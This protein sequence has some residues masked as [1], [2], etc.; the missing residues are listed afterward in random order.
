MDRYLMIKTRDE[1]LRIKIGQILYFEADRN[2]TKL[3]LS[4][5]IQFTFAINIG[6][7]EELLEKQVSGSNDMLV[8]VGKSHIINKTHILQINL[9]KQKLL[10]LTQEGKPREL[11]ISKD[12]L[13]QLKEALEKEV[14]KGL[15]ETKG[16]VLS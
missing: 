2:Y 9:P 13:K 3:L 14:E 16:D 6:K 7:I 4:N 8:R 12:P 1:L 10:L 15:E 11:V 5:G